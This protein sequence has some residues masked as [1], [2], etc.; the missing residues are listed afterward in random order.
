MIQINLFVSLLVFTLIGGCT[1]TAQHG[2]RTVD[3]LYPNSKELIITPSTPVLTLP[4]RV[5][6]AFVPG[7]GGGSY[8]HGS[9]KIFNS[10]FVLTEAKKTALMQEVADHFKK[11]D[12]IKDFALI[13]STDLSAGGSFANLDHI[14][15]THGVDII[16]LLSFDQVQ[17]TDEGVA[18]LTY[19]T[20]AGLYIVPGEKNDTSTLI[21]TVVYDIKSRKLLFRAPGTSNIKNL[22]TP[23]NLSEQLRIDSDQGF[24]KA[25][26]NMIINLEEQLARFRQKIKENPADFKVVK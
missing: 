18:S 24:D 26:K 20:I 14:R 11:Y 7:E 12:F 16:A 22:S 3:Y 5:G 25:A 23:V 6:I 1:G 8:E 2:T 21:D 17:F 4:I 15:N 13:P 10:T 19:L 9:G